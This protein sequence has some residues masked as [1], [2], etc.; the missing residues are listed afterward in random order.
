MALRIVAL[1]EAV[2]ELQRNPSDLDA[3]RLDQ[4]AQQLDKLQESVDRV[5]ARRKTV[6]R[7]TRHTPDGRIQEYE[8]RDEADVDGGA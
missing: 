4:I 8:Q 5:A 2:A 6:T 7:V 3:P 1:E